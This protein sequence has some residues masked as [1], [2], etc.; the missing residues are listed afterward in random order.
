MLGEN[1]DSYGYESQDSFISMSV[2]NG[3]KYQKA[4]KVKRK[5]TE[6]G[7]F[8]SE[9]GQETGGLNQWQFK[10]ENDGVSSPQESSPSMAES[11]P[12]MMQS[13]PS[14]MQ[15]S[16]SMMQSSP[17]MMQSSQEAEPAASLPPSITPMTQEPEP[18][19][20]SPSIQD[21]DNEQPESPIEA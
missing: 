6:I 1:F 7:S 20:S 3:L 15:S 10:T 21:D 4:T 2:K 8:F 14:M 5:L 12:S 11:S 9:A 16:P 17:S 13:S 19:P 18:E